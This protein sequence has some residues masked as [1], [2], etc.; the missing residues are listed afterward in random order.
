METAIDIIVAIQKIARKLENLEATVTNDCGNKQS[1]RE[2]LAN[3]NR[4]TDE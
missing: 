1:T 3:G 2:E 4:L